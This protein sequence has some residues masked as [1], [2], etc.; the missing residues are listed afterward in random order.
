MLTSI[1]CRTGFAVLICVAGTRAAAAQAI[2]KPDYVTYLP[3]DAVLPVQ[4]TPANRQF[5]LFGDATTPTYHDEAPRDGLAVH[6]P[7]RDD[8]VEVLLAEALQR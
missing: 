5:H 1:L 3:R 7:E 8:G 6:G 4:A 2:P